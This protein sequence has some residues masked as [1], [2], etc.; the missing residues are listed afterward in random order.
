MK[1]KIGEL[2]N[3]PD[4]DIEVS[5]CDNELLEITYTSQNALI[6]ITLDIDAAEK[7]LYAIHVF[8]GTAPAQVGQR[9]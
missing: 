9:P 5:N 6:E 4:C 3:R 8:L 1:N 2:V 7:L